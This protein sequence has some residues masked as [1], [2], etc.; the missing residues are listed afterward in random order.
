MLRRFL[1]LCLALLITTV[2][3][4]AQDSYR[5]QSGDRLSIEVLQDSD[6]NRNAVVLPDG[7]ISFPLAGTVRARGRT[8]S[9]I[10]ASLSAALAGNFQAPPDVFVSVEPAPKEDPLPP[11]PEPE[12]DMVLIYFLGEISSPGPKEMMEGTTFLQALSASGGFTNF[13]AT[14][15]VQLRRTDPQTGLQSV[16]E[17]D[18]NAL[19]EGAELRNNFPLLEGDVILVP[20][21]RL[22]E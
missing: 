4:S 19:S 14:K 11:A 5:V 8:V 1:G 6:L 15:R 9:Q 12:P 16:F 21:R 2:Q 3:A 13:A 20:E 17:I 10:Q 22:F 18:Y 7:R